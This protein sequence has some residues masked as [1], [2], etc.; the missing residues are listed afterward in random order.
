[1]IGSYLVP[2]CFGEAELVEKRSRFLSRVWPVENEEEALARIKDMREKHWDATHNV[3]AYII[4]EGL[5]MRYSD[6]G[7]PQG[8]SGLPT[9]NVLRSAGVYNACCVVTRYFGGTLLGTGGLVRAYSQ[10]AALAL[11]AAGTSHVRLWE[12]VMIACPYPLYERVKK[13][14]I[15]L[16]AVLESTDFAADVNMEALIEKGRGEE[17]SARL[18][19]I[20]S[21]TVETLIIGEEYK[22]VKLKSE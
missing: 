7:E 10:A 16:E 14:L 20:S 1:M 12:R 9:L 8:T 18:M 2:S 19:D 21:A 11:K 17:L 22:A 4:R 5:V 6:D 3:Y 15:Q 13:E